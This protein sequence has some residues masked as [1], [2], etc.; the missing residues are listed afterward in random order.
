[1]PPGNLEVI[2]THVA[3]LASPCFFLLL[4]PRFAWRRPP[5]ERVRAILDPPVCLL[6]TVIDV[7]LERSEEKKEDREKNCRATNFF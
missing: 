5:A 6:Q 2:F 1:M 3:S 4:S 7:H